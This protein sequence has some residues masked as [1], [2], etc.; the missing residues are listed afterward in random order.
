MHL[1]R[2][3][4]GNLCKVD[5]IN[6]SIDEQIMNFSYDKQWEFPFD[7]LRLGNPTIVEITTAI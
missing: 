6:Q 2:L 7:R 5:P 4:N 1:Q 3:L